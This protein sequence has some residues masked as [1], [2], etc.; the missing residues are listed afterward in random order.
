M[1]GVK[2]KIGC[3]ERERK[4]VEI[5]RSGEKTVLQLHCFH[6]RNGCETEGRRSTEVLCT[7]EAH[8]QFQSF[9]TSRFLEFQSE[10]LA[11]D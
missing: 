9:N 5:E 4:E 10:K 11:L 2:T 3:T 8:R 7:T 1:G 6:F